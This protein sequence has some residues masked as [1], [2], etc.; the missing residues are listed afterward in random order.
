MSKPFKGGDGRHLTRPPPAP[1]PNPR[2]SFP[3]S[4]PT[5]SCVSRLGYDLEGKCKDIAARRKAAGGARGGGGGRGGNGAAAHVVAGGP[6]GKGHGGAMCAGGKHGGGGGRG[7][8][9]SGG[10]SSPNY[11]SESVIADIYG[12]GWGQG[13]AAA[14]R[15]RK[16]RASR[17]TAS[18]RMRGRAGVVLR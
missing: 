4:A 13:G 11:T 14:A 7:E 6:S 17:R 16:T 12:G 3:S 15:E 10:R 8:G 9:S 1:L 18:V 5:S 2:F